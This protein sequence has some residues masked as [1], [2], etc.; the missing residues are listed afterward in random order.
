M[1]QKWQNY[2][3]EKFFLLL[4]LLTILIVILIVVFV[5]SRSLPA[6]EAG[7]LFN[8]V[9]GL[10][11]APLNNKFG[12]FAMIVG[13]I[14]VTLG[15][16][17]LGVPFGVGAAI[18]L[19]EIAPSWIQKI[20]RPAVELLAGIPSVI[21]GLFGMTLVVPLIRSWEKSILG[22]GGDPHLQVGYS[23]L[24]A[25]F[26]LTIMILPTI[27][28]VAEDALR[29]VPNDYKEG[30]YALG[31]TRWQTIVNVVLPASRSGVLA[32]IILGMGR[33]IGETMAVI[34]VA[35]N[36]PLL[37]TSIFSPVRTLTS[38]IAIESAYATGL[39]ESA[40]FATGV[41]LLFF[42]I[43]LEAIAWAVRRRL[44]FND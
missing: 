40:L 25:V 29:A 2:L 28:N 38:N 32:A 7:G 1:H 22:P 24:A 44:T 13:S 15:A 30:S 43:L 14:A 3:L 5:V 8:I 37:P 20:I 34:M 17:I 18:F 4:A 36:T 41:V 27:T 19:A 10:E 12:I 33:A 6:F 23:V 9:F 31:A 39:H 26:V 42:I 16:L 35:G 21:Y 11:W